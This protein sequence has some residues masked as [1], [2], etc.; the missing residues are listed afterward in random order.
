MVYLPKKF[1]TVWVE[2]RNRKATKKFWL[3]ERKDKI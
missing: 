2:E 3:R 1:L